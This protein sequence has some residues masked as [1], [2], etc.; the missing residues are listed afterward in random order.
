MA[1]RILSLLFFLSASCKSTTTELQTLDFGVFKLKAPQDWTIIKEQGID[2]YIGGL[3]N[4][5][6]SLWFDYG[7]YT[8]DL[9][10]AENFKHL[11]AKDTVNGFAATVMKPDTV[12]KGYTSIYVPRIT[13]NDKLTIWGVNIQEQDVVLKMFKSIVFKNSD[14]LKNPEL[15]ESKFVYSSYG[16]RKTLF[17]QNCASCHSLNKELTG[18]ALIDVMQKRNCDWLYTFLTNRKATIKDSIYL[19]L[20]K[21]YDTQCQQF[22][23]LSKEDVEFLCG[24]L[25]E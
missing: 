25:L 20:Y 18:P 6:D 12:G 13:K 10:E 21:K 14:T 2:S 19:A 15:T 24:F 1:I 16:N 8:V 9:G 11:F 5:K 3:T 23:N 4:G 22:P 7:Q 17:F